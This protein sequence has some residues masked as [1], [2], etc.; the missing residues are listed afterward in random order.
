MIDSSLAL[1]AQSM[2]G[3]PR[4][5]SHRKDEAWRIHETAIV[6]GTFLR[7]Y[8][9]SQAEVEGRRGGVEVR[10]QRSPSWS[11]LV[12]SAGT[13]RKHPLALPVLTGD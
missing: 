1:S 5:V 3:C 4:C 10:V 9:K 7:A 13:C 8:V 2:Q 6:R 11:V 12:C